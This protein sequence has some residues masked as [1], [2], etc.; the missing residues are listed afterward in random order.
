M[1][2][3]AESPWPMSFEEFAE[4]YFTRGRYEL[5]D[6]QRTLGEKVWAALEEAWR[7]EPGADSIRLDIPPQQGRLLG[8]STM[9]YGISAA[10]LDFDP[11]LAMEPK[12]FGSQVFAISEVGSR[13][14]RRG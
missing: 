9:A 14:P 8:R 13:W 5:T 12:R 3:V 6:W 2:E 4:R 1:A 10:M 11:T 7:T